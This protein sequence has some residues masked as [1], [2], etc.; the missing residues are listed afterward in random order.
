LAFAEAHSYVALETYVVGA[1][2]LERVE[3]G[4]QRLGVRVVIPLAKYC[5]V[6]GASVLVGHDV[7]VLDVVFDGFGHTASSKSAVDACVRGDTENKQHY[8]FSKLRTL[9]LAVGCRT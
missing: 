6:G 5:R 1:R 9:L 2:E 7:L 3:T 4:Q 8:G